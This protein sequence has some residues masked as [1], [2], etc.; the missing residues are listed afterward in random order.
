MGGQACVL[1]GAAEFSRDT[2][3]AL[4][5]DSGNIERLEAALRELRA[6]RIAVPPL[7]ADYLRRGHAVHFRCHDPDAEGMRVD[8]MSVMRGVD[9]FPALWDRRTSVE[10]EAGESFDMLSLPDLVLAKK[11]QRDRD[12]P[13]IRRLVEAHYVQHRE[14]VTPERVAFWLRESRTPSM[15]AG[16][17]AEFPEEARSACRQRPLLGGALAG[18]EIGLQEELDREEKRERELDRQYWIPLKQEL[19]RCAASGAADHSCRSASTGSIA[20]ARRAGR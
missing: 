2:D 20:S 11:T 6:E 4:L 18:D 14:A 17:A 16:L 9:P 13:M 12:W 3:I 1:Y 8:V 15:L 19:E 5:G 10:L 7:T